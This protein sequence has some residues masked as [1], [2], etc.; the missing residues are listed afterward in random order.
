M[1]RAKIL[2][3]SI[4]AGALLL[5]L[6][7]SVSAEWGDIIMNSKAEAMR[8]AE[9][10]DVLFPHWFHRIRFKCK[11]CHEDFFILKAGAN[12]VDMSNIANG[13]YC[14]NCH[15][16]EVAWP[17]LYCERCHSQEPGWTPGPIQHSKRVESE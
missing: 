17:P 14:G 1:K 7:S 5:P 4:L 3:L 13:Q 10:N 6:S 16:G 8:E 11:V 15:N 12:D 2:L 9:V